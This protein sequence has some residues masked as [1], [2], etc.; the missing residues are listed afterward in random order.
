MNNMAYHIPVLLH[1]AV[2]A[3]ITT[4]SGTYVDATLGGGG[5]TREVLSRLDV[6]ARVVAFDHD[7]DAEANLP[8][9]ERLHFVPANFMFMKNHL[10]FM[11]IKQVDGVLADLGVSSHQFDTPERGFSMRTDAPLDMRMDRK[12]PRTAAKVLQKSTEEQLAHL[13]RHYAEIREWRHL[14]AAIAAARLEKPVKTTGELM[15]IALKVCKDPKP[16]RF[17]AKVF[18]ALRIEVN[19][20]M[21]ALEAL[22]SQSA[23]LIKPGG[24]LVILSYHSLEDRMVKHFM[25]SGNADDAQE[26]D[27]FGRVQRPFT[28]MPG[29]PVMPGDDEVKLNS[30]ARSA[31]LRIAIKNE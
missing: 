28:P 10:K 7:Q 19:A 18:Q 13:F 20:E 24:R 6:N 14:A 22:L 17:L 15:Q 26:K 8:H 23:E 25:R 31:R 21:K 30:R 16:N 3:L 5:H 12:A 1:E 11:G 4:T 27:F 29:M 2:D 9:D